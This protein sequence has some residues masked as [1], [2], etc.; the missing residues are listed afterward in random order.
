MPD[1][2]SLYTKLGLSPGRNTDTW[3]TEQIA[4]LYSSDYLIWTNRSSLLGRRGGT[5]KPEG[6]LTLGVRL[7]ELTGQ[8]VSRYWG[9]MKL[10]ADVELVNT[11]IYFA[12]ADGTVYR[13][14]AQA[15]LTTREEEILRLRENVIYDALYGRRYVTE[16]MNLPPE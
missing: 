8:S 15:D 16:E 3:S 10:A 13:N 4:D 11:D 2:E 1:G 7:C 14:R 9:L 6:V 5:V 12:D